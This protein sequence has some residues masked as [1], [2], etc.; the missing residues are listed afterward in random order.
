MLVVSVTII[1]ISV[2]YEVSLFI[3]L[4][5]FCLLLLSSPFLPKNVNVKIQ[6][7]IILLYT[8]EGEILSVTLRE[9]QRLRV[10][11]DFTSILNTL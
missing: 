2:I 6:R 8:Y 3:S 4:P 1:A 11:Q 7:L 9:E 5:P 10:F